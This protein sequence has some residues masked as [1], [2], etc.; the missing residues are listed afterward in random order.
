M[1]VLGSLINSDADV[2]SVSL[3][4][5]RGSRLYYRSGPNQERQSIETIGG[6]TN[7]ILLPKS[8]EL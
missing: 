1:Q 8:L 6:H 5:K 3:E 7:S 2:R 4:I